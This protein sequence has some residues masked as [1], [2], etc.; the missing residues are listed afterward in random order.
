MTYVTGGEC[1]LTKP[2]DRRKWNRLGFN[3][4]PCS[5]NSK[6]VCSGVTRR[7]FFCPLHDNLF[8]DLLDWYFMGGI[9]DDD[10]GPLT[11][12]GVP[13]LKSKE[14]SLWFDSD[15]HA[16]EVY[17]IW[18]VTGQFQMTYTLCREFRRAWCRYYVRL[19]PM[20]VKRPRWMRGHECW[21]GTSIEFC[22]RY[23]VQM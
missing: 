10:T 3:T 6:M 13:G 14:V 1:G 21:K 23:G 17:C 5:F 15:F 18:K 20:D 8:L 9:R 4:L 7:T 11:I 12:R 19:K 16:L 2:R 22:K